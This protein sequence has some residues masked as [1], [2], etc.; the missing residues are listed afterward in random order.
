MKV[1]QIKTLIYT[2]EKKIYPICEIGASVFV[3]NSS[4]HLT[5]I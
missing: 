5:I 1:K 3:L 4:S 2:Y